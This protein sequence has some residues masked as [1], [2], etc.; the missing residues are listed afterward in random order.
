MTKIIQMLEEV[1]DARRIP[2]PRRHI[3][4]SEA[5]LCTNCDTLFDQTEG[6]SCP[7]CTSRHAIPAG[8]FLRGAA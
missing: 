8:R 4:L 1:I 7:A 3:H 5:M 2:Q 6:A